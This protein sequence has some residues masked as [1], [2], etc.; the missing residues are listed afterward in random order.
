MIPYSPKEADDV[1]LN[2]PYAD[3]LVINAEQFIIQTNAAYKNC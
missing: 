2:T 3:V 1:V